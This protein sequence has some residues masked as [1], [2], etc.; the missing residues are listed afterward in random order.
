MLVQPGKP[1]GHQMWGKTAGRP[2][3]RMGR[4]TQRPGA[5]MVM[6]RMVGRGLHDA[7]RAWPAQRGVARQGRFGVDVVRKAAR[8]HIGIFKR[9]VGPL[10]QKGQR[11]VGRVTQKRQAM[12]VPHLRDGVTE[13]TPQMH[14]IGPIQKRTHLGAEIDKGTRQ[15]G[16][17][18]ALVPALGNPS[19]AFFDRHDIDKPPVP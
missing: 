3:G 8:Q 9:H 12:A 2:E 18:V 16:G 10:G 17:V 13:Q 1:V 4:K 6:A 7:G 15:M 5:Q 14:I 19:L 11:G